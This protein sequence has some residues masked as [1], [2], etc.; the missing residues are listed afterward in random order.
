MRNARSLLVWILLGAAGAVL[1]AWA[2]PRA[3]PFAPRGWR[4][5]R[6]EAVAIALSRLKDLGEPVENSYVVARLNAQS[7]LER[8]LELALG[9]A[10][11]RA[12]RASGLADRILDWEVYV[13]PPEALRDDWTYRAS[14]PL[15]GDW[16]RGGGQHGARTG[17]SDRGYRSDWSGRRL[18]LVELRYGRGWGSPLRRDE[19]LRLC[20][21][22]GECLHTDTKR[23]GVYCDDQHRSDGAG[24]WLRN[25]RKCGVC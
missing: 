23:D 13:Y 4:V 9:K 24:R 5:T 8:R 17:G 15:W 16:T 3:F 11:S 10:G 20:K 12:V 6:S 18:E 19:R 21:Q 25:L 2:Y 14:R 22:G 1:F 7:L